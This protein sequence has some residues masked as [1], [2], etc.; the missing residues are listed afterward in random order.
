MTRER[1]GKS[2]LPRDFAISE[3]VRVWARAHCPNI[4]LAGEFEKF[5]DYWWGCG[6]KMA[7]WDA[8]LR[9]WLRRAPQFSRGQPKSRWR[10]EGVH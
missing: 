6:R 4:D 7:D 2:A 10:P 1:A 9:N 8:T 3:E 5:C